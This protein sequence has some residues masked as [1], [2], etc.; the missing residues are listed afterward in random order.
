MV[1]PAQGIH[2]NNAPFSGAVHQ[3]PG[4]VNIISFLGDS[5]KITT[6]NYNAAEEGQDRIGATLW[7][8]PQ[9]YWEH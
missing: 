5:E 4:K 7:E 1:T 2:L 6:R 3:S 9:K 8:Q